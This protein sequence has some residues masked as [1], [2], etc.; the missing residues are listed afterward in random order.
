M[1]GGE[2]DYRRSDR[3]VPRTHGVLSGYQP[4][5]HERTDSFASRMASVSGPALGRQPNNGLI[6]EEKQVVKQDAGERN[7]IEGKC[8]YGLDCLRARQ[9]KTS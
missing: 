8:K 3:E 6:S 9:A 5:E 1:K 2:K 7:A 4:T